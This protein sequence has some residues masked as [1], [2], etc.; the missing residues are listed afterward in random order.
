VDGAECVVV[1]KEVL[2]KPRCVAIGPECLFMFIEPYCEV[3]AGLTHIIN[4]LCLD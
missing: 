3:S 2:G 4:L 1:F